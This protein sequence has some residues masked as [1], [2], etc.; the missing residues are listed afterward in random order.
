MWGLRWWSTVEFKQEGGFKMGEHKDDFKRVELRFPPRLLRELD[1]I[2]EANRR[3]RNS[4]LVMVVDGYVRE[5]QQ[6]GGQ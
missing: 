5:Q 2:A 3:S 4:E 6:K 1:E